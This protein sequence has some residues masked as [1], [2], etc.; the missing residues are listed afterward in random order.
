MGLKGGVIE[1]RA[2]LWVPYG[3]DTLRDA[4]DDNI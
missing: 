2:S 4:W 3:L 1:L